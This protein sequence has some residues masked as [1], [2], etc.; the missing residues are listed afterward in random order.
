MKIVDY[1]KNKMGKDIIK[2]F[3]AIYPDLPIEEVQRMEY[4]ENQKSNVCTKVA[5]IDDKVVGQANVFRLPNNPTIAN[6]GYHVH[7]SYRRRG[8]GH[9]LS[10][11]TMK[12]AKKSGIKTITVQT[13]AD[14]LEAIILARK[15]GFGI[16]PKDFLEENESGLK[17]HKLRNGICLYKKMRNT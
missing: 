13:E 11:K 16:A 17:I 7:P 4:D 10:I 6:L 2:L 3:S 14:N 8:I 9:K 15:L 12:I 5:I 1:S